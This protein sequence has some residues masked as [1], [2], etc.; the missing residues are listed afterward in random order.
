[1]GQWMC[2]ICWRIDRWLHTH[3]TKNTLFLA[4]WMNYFSCGL[5]WKKVVLST[6]WVGHVETGHTITR[7]TVVFCLIVWQFWWCLCLRYRTLKEFMYIRCTDEVRYD[8][9]RR[10]E[11]NMVLWDISIVSVS[12]QLLKQWWYRCWLLY[13]KNY[14]T[15]KTQSRFAVFFKFHIFK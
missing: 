3:H 4:E 11:F 8:Y 9:Q 7:H 2:G 13:S 14:H 10:L 1:M 5:I 15:Y 12:N 6:K